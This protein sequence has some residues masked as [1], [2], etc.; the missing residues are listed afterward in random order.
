MEDTAFALDK[1]GKSRL[2]RI[3]LILGSLF[4]ILLIIIYWDDVGA[5]H[6]Y[7][8]T[9]ISGL[10]S[11]HHLAESHSIP[12]EK[13]DFDKETSFLSDIDAFINQFL[14]ATTEPS[15]HSRED[16]KTSLE[17]SGKITEH[18]EEYVPQ[19]AW[20][21]HLAPI[22]SE[23]KQRQNIRKQLL[24]D[25]C[26][27]NTL[28]FPGKNRTFDDI[29]NKEL[30]H[31]IVDDRHGIIYCYV[32]KVACSNWKRIM[33]VLTESLLNDGVP[34]HNP[35][36]IPLEH[37]HNSSLHFTFNKF[38]KRYG[39][40]SRH[41]MK[42]K[43]KKYTKFLF[44]RDPFVR[45][46]S[47]YRNKF[48]QENEDFYKRFAVV[49]LKKYSNYTDP[50]ASV[51]KAFAAGIRPS[52]SNFIQYLLDPQT[53]QEMPFNE[54]WRQVYRLC[55]PCQINYDF[56]GKLETLEDDAEHL[57]RILRVDNIVQFPPGYRNR[58]A[59]SWEEEWFASIP[60]KWRRELYR[61]YEADFTL[62]GYSKPEKILH[63]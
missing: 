45:L 5:T 57:L 54:H 43:L 33:I 1:M 11:S 55:H 14:E 25:V 46:I 36:D 56:V 7:L 31:L 32:P 50:P 9:T 30:D 58:T 42:I 38:W 52:F 6:F 41:L 15:M 17:M 8:H 27:N 49:M 29:P 3:S 4:M 28:D 24:H 35:L 40:F 53:E 62:F 21:V 2:F 51:V 34:Y 26:T 10:Q 47:A 61:L 39:K 18:E 22:S 48:L 12:K 19:R 44:V 37:V 60:Y 59:S 20:K 13:T 63:E 23:R 16:Q